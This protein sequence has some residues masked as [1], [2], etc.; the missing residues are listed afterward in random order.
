MAVRNL[1]FGCPYGEK[2]N[3]TPCVGIGSSSELPHGFVPAKIRPARSVL[4]P[5]GFS[6]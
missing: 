1:S 6:F 2:V 5:S 4:T 3:L